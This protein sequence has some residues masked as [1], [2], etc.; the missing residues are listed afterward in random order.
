[1]YVVIFLFLSFF[2]SLLTVYFQVKALGV[3]R[4]GSFNSRA[5]FQYI[6]QGTQLKRHRSVIE[7]TSPNPWQYRILSEYIAELSVS[8]VK[9]IGVNRPIVCGFL[10]FR[11]FQNALIFFLLFVYYKKLGLSKNA[12]AIGYCILAWGFS[13]AVY[14]SGLSFDIYSDVIFYVLAGLVVLYKKYIWVVPIVFFAALNRE[15]S[16]LICLLPLAIDFA[17]KPQIRFPKK[18]TLITLIS[19]CLFVVVYFGL[20]LI[21]GPRELAIPYGNHPGIELFVYNYGRSIT[22]IQL[23]ATLSLI[24]MVA[25]VSIRSWPSNL[26]RFFWAIVPA[27]FLIHSFG[28]VMAESRLFLVP[29]AVVFVPGALFGLSK[30]EKIADQHA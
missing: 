20:R 24:P 10:L 23:F 16:G 4:F 26:K 11:F 30:N 8:L 21:L 9:T 13:N 22:W 25:I 27:W 5:A 2:F 15:T 19:L 1:M 12:I 18:A 14:D 3:S 7:G 17:L 6:E 29:L 28:S